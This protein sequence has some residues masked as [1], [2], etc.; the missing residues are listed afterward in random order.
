MVLPHG[1]ESV[2]S[3]CAFFW[4]GL[5]DVLKVLGPTFIWWADREDLRVNSGLRFEEADQ[6]ETSV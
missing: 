4:H 3:M 5:I 1:I 6:M 2:W